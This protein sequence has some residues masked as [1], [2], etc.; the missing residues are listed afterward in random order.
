M[1]IRLYSANYKNN[2]APSFYHIKAGPILVRY[3]SP[4]WMMLNNNNKSISKIS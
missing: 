1:V 4:P 3:V 2:A